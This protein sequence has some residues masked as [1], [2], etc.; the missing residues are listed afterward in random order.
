MTKLKQ[1]LKEFLKKKKFELFFNKIFTFFSTLKQNVVVN[2]TINNIFS[3]V[4][5]HKIISTAVTISIIAVPSLV[6]SNSY[7][8]SECNGLIA[9][10]D[11]RGGMPWNDNYVPELSR[12]AFEEDPKRLL[13]K[14]GGMFTTYDD[15][16][17][18]TLFDAKYS[19][20]ATSSGKQSAEVYR[21]QIAV[22]CRKYRNKYS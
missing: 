3:F 21:E 2:N 15:D 22:A 16:V 10:I 18:P 8:P 9:Q 1:L 13:G 17:L 14:S 5:Q 7:Y 6:G 12:L 4:K 20:L 19:R 11:Y